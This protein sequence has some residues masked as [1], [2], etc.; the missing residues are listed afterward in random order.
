MKNKIREIEIIASPS[1]VYYYARDVKNANI[2]HAE[3]VLIK[4]GDGKW[5]YNFANDIPDANIEKLQ[6]AILNTKQGEWISTFAKN[7]MGADIDK[8]Q[9][10]VLESNDAKSMFYF[11]K[12]VPNADIEKLKASEGRTINSDFPNNYLRQLKKIIT[13]GEYEVVLVPADEEIRN[14]LYKNNITFAFL[15]SDNSD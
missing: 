5:I 12:D 10:A 14:L 9:Q 8:M 13:S 7:I 15:A 1:F 4:L 2:Q 11:A 6:E 3:D